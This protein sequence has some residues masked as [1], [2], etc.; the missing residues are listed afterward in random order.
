MECR[1]EIIMSL[2][3]KSIENKYNCILDKAFGFDSGSSFWTCFDKDMEYICDGY[4]LK[5]IEDKLKSK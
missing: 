3:K 4:T 5:E 1:K 2:T